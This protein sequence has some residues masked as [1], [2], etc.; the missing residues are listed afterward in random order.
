VSH[1][2]NTDKSTTETQQFELGSTRHCCSSAHYIFNR[3]TYLSG[4]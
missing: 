4:S 3:N 2:H 1:P